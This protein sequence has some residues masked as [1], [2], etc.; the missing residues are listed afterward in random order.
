MLQ[1]GSRMA[2]DGVKDHPR[3]LRWMRHEWA[4]RCSR[5]VLGCPRM[6]FKIILGSFLWIRR[7][8]AAGCSRRK[9][10]KKVHRSFKS[11][12]DLIILSHHDSFAHT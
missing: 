2:H 5:M 3:I 10:N 1:D 9:R 4:P 8:S 7:K 6:V 12:E 11:V